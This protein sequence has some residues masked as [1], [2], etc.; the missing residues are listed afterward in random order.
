[1][2]LLPALLPPVARGHLGMSGD[3]FHYQKLGGVGATSIWC[4]EAR[5]AAK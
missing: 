3:T 4:V 2:V 1:M 5:D